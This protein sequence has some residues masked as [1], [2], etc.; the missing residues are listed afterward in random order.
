M[1]DP[2]GLSFLLYSGS[3]GYKDRPYIV[4]EYSDKYIEDLLEVSQAFDLT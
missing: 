2:Q 1:E 4:S 3:Q